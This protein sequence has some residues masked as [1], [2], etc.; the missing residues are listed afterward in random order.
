MKQ[1]EHPL[2]EAFDL[3]A[4]LHALSDPYRLSVVQK[5]AEA[6]PQPCG[7]LQAGR[8]KSSVSHHFMVLRR[9]G[10]VRTEVVGALHMNSLRDTELEQ[11]FPGLLSAVL[12]A[13][14]SEQE[15]RAG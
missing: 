12:K 14:Q 1:Y 4:V 7:P 13:A 9:A 8:P 2:V 3:T 6:Q 11:R 5:L 10:V 15:C